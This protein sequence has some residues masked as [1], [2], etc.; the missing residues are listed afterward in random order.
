[1]VTRGEVGGGGMIKVMGIM[2]G[3]CEEHRVLYESDESLHFT[4]ETNIN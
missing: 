3:T 4:P 1:M 2:E